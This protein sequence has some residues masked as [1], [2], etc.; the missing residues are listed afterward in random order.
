MSESA[1]RSLPGK[2][3]AELS[4]ALVDDVFGP[5]VAA[6]AR[7]L[8]FY[9]RGD[10]R[11][12]VSQSHLSI[13]L[14][15]HALVVL[16]QHRIVQAL[17]PLSAG[18]FD[19][20]FLGKTHYVIDWRHCIH[21][22]RAGKVIWWI[23][24]ILPGRDSGAISYAAAIVKY[25]LLQGRCRVD[26]IWAALL[27]ADD[28]SSDAL[29]LAHQLNDALVNLV[30]RGFLRPVTEFDLTPE[31]DLYERTYAEIARPEPPPQTILPGDTIKVEHSEQGDETAAMSEQAR[32]AERLRQFQSEKADFKSDAEK[33]RFF[34][35]WTKDIM[36]DL[37]TEHQKNGLYLIHGTDPAIAELENQQSKRQSSESV[38]NGDK[39]STKRRKGP[40]GTAEPVYDAV[41]TLLAQH[42]LFVQRS[43][44]VRFNYDKILVL[45][46]NE[47][48][49]HLCRERHGDAVAEVF[50]AVLSI[51]EPKLSDCDQWEIDPVTT[52]QV[53]R[54]LVPTIDLVTMWEDADQLRE[55]EAQLRDQTDRASVGSRKRKR[56]HSLSDSGESSSEVDDHGEASKRRGRKSKTRS[57]RHSRS[58]SEDSADDSDRASTRRR[59]R[60]RR[61]HDSVTE[62]ESE[63]DE[64][65]RRSHR[66]SK[67]GRKSASSSKRSSRASSRSS[68]HRSQH[69]R[70]SRSSSESTEHSSDSQSDDHRSR[71]S[72]K[73]RRSNGSRSGKRHSRKGARSMSKK[74]SSSRRR[75]RSRDDNHSHTDGSDSESDS[76]DD[77][78]RDESESGESDDSD[79]LRNGHGRN[80]RSQSFDRDFDPDEARELR[81][82]SLRIRLIDR[83]LDLLA[84]DSTFKFVERVGEP[85][86]TE[87]NHRHNVTA[88]IS[89]AWRVDLPGLTKTLASFEVERHV[90][91][92]SGTAA[93]DIDL[94]LL[95]CVR[96]NEK[97]DEKQLATQ[98]LMTSADVR[99]RLTGLHQQGILQLQEVPKRQ[100]RQPSTT[101]YLWWYDEERAERRLAD[102]DVMRALA[103][104]QDRLASFLNDDEHV[105]LVRKAERTDAAAAAEDDSSTPP[106]ITSDRHTN[107]TTLTT[108]GSALT[109]SVDELKRLA[110][111]RAIE[112]LLRAQLIRLLRSYDVLTRF[113]RAQ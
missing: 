78:S 14:V 18:A 65:D 97:I 26:D 47:A 80:K 11:T 71:R 113:G 16:L 73:S 92:I 30:K 67:R 10:I 27:P 24:K 70:R 1:Q 88:T 55:E 111:D 38:I 46:R 112:R 82:S 109:L 41:Q 72:G 108:N 101:F 6:V 7:A 35:Q 105:R 22:A 52:V 33:K 51:I 77:D 28:K 62:S 86:E 37:R 19:T 89:S 106:S 50:A 95:R 79:H 102:V 9:G 39:R 84:A 59:R 32:R 8:L 68:R 17:T 43:C 54:K 96:A 53:L 36:Q 57:K 66:H 48:L 44:T 42:G 100:D 104:T 23:S 83:V 87:S 5:N 3:A 40:R 12:I 90:T 74:S 85:I 2:A 98:C 94:R 61:R 4:I 69:S 56:A 99:Q 103:R 21:L 34:D 75:H 29:L 76:S 81:Q 60:R 64:D 93:G 13:K 63:S 15:K 91:S 20:D 45:E 49:I 107:T 110:R 58:Q 31:H 25:V